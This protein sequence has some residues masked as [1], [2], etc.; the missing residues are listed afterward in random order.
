MSI[1][2]RIRLLA[3]SQSYTIAALEREVSLGRGT[4][5]KWDNNIPSAD[6]LQ[7]VANLLQ[8]SME[9]LLTGNDKNNPMQND[10]N[11]TNMS[12]DESD[13]LA[14]FRQLTRKNQRAILVQMENMLDVSSVEVDDSKES[15]PKKS[16]A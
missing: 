8:C 11:S 14:Y 3:E 10:D 7:R 2:E 6:K 4:I 5:R 12:E 9:Y 16:L 15:E 13:L 1:V